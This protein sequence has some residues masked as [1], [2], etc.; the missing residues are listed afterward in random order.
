VA[1]VFGKVSKAATSKAIT[2]SREAKAAAD[3]I[4]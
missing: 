2:V 1:E 4:Y 3:M